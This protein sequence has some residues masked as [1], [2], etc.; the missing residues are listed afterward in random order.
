MTLFL[1]VAGLTGS[2]LAWNTPLERALWAP[3]RIVNPPSADAKVIDPFDLR[4]RAV[5]EIPNVVGN[6]VDFNADEPGR[7]RYFELRASTNKNHL[8]TAASSDDQVYLDPY[9]GAELGRRKAGD[10]TQGLKNLMPFIYRVHYTLALGIIGS[11]AFGIVALLWTLDCFVGA[12]LTFPRGRPFS[13]K[14]L[15]AWLVY[16]KRF[17]FDLHRAGGLWLWAMLFVFAW[18]SVGFNLA[19]VLYPSYAHPVRLPRRLR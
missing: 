3:L 12:Y 15:P 10:I 6:R 11:Y 8:A 4:D 9:T 17:N 19:Q 16:W 1:V 14:W 18:S 13:R 2:L 7:P 5:A